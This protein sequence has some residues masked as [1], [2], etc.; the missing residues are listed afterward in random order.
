MSEDEEIHEEKALGIWIP[1]EDIQKLGVVNAAL[2]QLICMLHKAKGCRASNKYLSKRLKIS[3]RSV[4]SGIKDLTDAGYISSKMTKKYIGSTCIG[5]VRLVVPALHPSSK[6][7]DTPLEKSSTP[8][9]A[10]S[11]S[12]NKRKDLNKREKKKEEVKLNKSGFSLSLLKE[13]GKMKRGF[14]YLDK[15]RIVLPQNGYRPFEKEK[16][17][18]VNEKD[19]EELL[20]HFGKENFWLRD[21]SKSRKIDRM[22]KGDETDNRWD[23]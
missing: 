3:E 20:A 1:D 6:F 22:E 13:Q 19:G 4:T 10:N 12:I 16:F 21:V 5:T 2:F 9:L 18:K 23:T 15:L 11:A 7:C 14:L 17:Q 8:P